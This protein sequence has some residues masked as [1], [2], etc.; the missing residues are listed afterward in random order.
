MQRTHLMKHLIKLLVLTT[1]SSLICSMN[2][3]LNTAYQHTG[4]Q[5]T[6]NNALKLESITREIDMKFSSH[7][8]PINFIV[9]S[10][11]PTIK[12]QDRLFFMNYIENNYAEHSPD[13]L[14]DRLYKQNDLFRQAA[15]FYIDHAHDNLRLLSI[16]NIK[17]IED[18]TKQQPTMALNTLK[19]A[20]KNFVMHK[21]FKLVDCSYTIKLPHESRIICFDICNETRQAATATYDNTLTLWNL[22]NGKIEHVMSKQYPINII[23]FNK[24]GSQLATAVVND[25]ACS[26]LVWCTKT[27]TILHT[28]KNLEE[29]YAIGY[30]LPQ[31][32]MLISQHHS[33]NYACS[34]HQLWKIAPST[35]QEGENIGIIARR[36]L[37]MPTSPAADELKAIES[38][39]D[40][41][42]YKAIHPNMY[43]ASPKTQLEITKKYAWNLYMCKQA[44]NKAIKD[45]TLQ[46]KI[47]QSQSFHA[48]TDL[49]K[50]IVYDEINKK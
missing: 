27:K 13:I 46:N 14:I 10:L 48:L 44:I 21:V 19:P 33:P 4:L 37:T 45:Q 47:E 22:T 9:F 24:N 23:T 25:T 26:I 41:P 39:T 34:Y 50:K 1:Y 20:A 29:I 11:L 38:G 3:A 49:E 8:P 32:G 28:I 18:S 35:A 2:S 40:T 31:S 30:G 17:T 6:Q 5:T 42:R 7:Y 12:P 15:D 36:G 16:H 43:I